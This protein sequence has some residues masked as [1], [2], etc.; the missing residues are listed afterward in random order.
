MDNQKLSSW[1]QV[2]DC[3]ECYMRILVGSN[4]N[5]IKNRI[6]FIEKTPRIR[7]SWNNTEDYLNWKYGPKGSGDELGL[8]EPSRE[9][10]DSELKLMG[11]TWD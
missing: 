10:C 4:P 2:P 8:Y 1:I 11:Y 6:A 7:I 9:W 5:E 3:E